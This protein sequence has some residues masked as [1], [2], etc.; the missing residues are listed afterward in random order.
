M[1]KETNLEF[2]FCI[3][4]N[5]DGSRIFLIFAVI[6]S[7]RTADKRNLQKN[8]DLFKEKCK[9][10]FSSRAFRGIIIWMHNA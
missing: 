7:K 3:I 8:S 10:N 9:K 6:E 5:K 2:P 1:K 4:K